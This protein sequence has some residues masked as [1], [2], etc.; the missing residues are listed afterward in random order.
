MNEIQIVGVLAVVA[1]I[2]WMFAFPKL[3]GS[4]EFGYGKAV[5]KGLTQGLVALLIGAAMVYFG[6]DSSDSSG[7]E[8]PPASNPGG[9]GQDSSPS[10]GSSQQA[11]PSDA[12]VQQ[13]PPSGGVQQVPPSAGVQQ[14]PP[15]GGVQQV[16][17][18][19][20]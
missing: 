5:A 12:G 18:D 9:A 1:G 15:S 19:V 11:P 6:R 7:S 14:P 2:V 20:R 13:P 4:S 8:A 17:P 16:P 3:T 10:D